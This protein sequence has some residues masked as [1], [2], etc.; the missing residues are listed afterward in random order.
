MNQAQT[1]ALYQPVLQAIAFKMLGSLADAEDIVQ[2]TFLK[3]LTIEQEKINNTK[4]YLIRAVTNN[5]LNHLNA[6]KQKK[7]E[8]LDNL[9]P[10]ELIEKFKDSDFG[11]FDLDNEIATAL[12]VIHKKLAPMEKAVF[13]LREVFDFDYEE[14]QVIL[15][16]K[17]ENCRQLFCRANEKLNQEKKKFTI[18]IPPIPS[19]NKM[20][21][22]FKNACKLGQLSDFIHELSQEVLSHKK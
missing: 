9:N 13:L 19:H 7:K 15:D 12:E 22:S 6:L 1:I 17:K 20:L 16:K 18:N 4:S 10:G 8:Y 2:D 5:C 3:W 14:L 21:E 11:H